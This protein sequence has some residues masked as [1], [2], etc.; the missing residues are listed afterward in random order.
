MAE[1]WWGLPNRE[2]KI[3]K[4]QGRTWLMYSEAE[5][6]LELGE[7][8]TKF[9]ENTTDPRIDNCLAPWEAEHTCLPAMSMN[10]TILLCTQYPKWL[11]SLSLFNCLKIEAPLFGFMCQHVCGSHKSWLGTHFQRSCWGRYLWLLASRLKAHKGVRSLPYLSICFSSPVLISFSTVRREH[12]K[13]NLRK[14][15]PSKYVLL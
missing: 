13:G 12:R 14:Y 7:Q 3:C 11:F 15:M 2:A 8:D 6:T 5:K 1:G 4:I 9:P 10:V